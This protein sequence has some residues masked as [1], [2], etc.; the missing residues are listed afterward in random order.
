TLIVVP[1]FTFPWLRVVTRWQARR[2]GEVLL[3]SLVSV[4]LA[5]PWYA[6]NW[7][8]TGD[9]FYPLYENIFPGARPGLGSANF[10]GF[11]IEKNL[12]NLALLPIQLITSGDKF[13]EQG[14]GALGV[15]PLLAIAAPLCATRLTRRLLVPL[16]VVAGCAVVIWFVVAQYDRYLLPIMPALSVMAAVSLLSILTFARV[17]ALPW[18][19]ALVIIGILAYAGL[20]R[21]VDARS[22]FQIAEGYPFAMAL[23]REPREKLLARSFGPYAAMAYIN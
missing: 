6:H 5:T 8:V 16:L 15:I 22:H 1:A 17:R 18:L 2:L 12:L 23:G 4:L 7:L 14:I 13:A 9:P 21:G 3:A 20:T 11:G 19:S 10:T